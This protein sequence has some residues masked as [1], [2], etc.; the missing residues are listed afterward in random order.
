M[1]HT[2]VLGALVGALLQAAL[3]PGV[4]VFHH[5]PAACLS[6]HSHVLRFELFGW[7]TVLTFFFIMVMYA[8]IFADP[9]HGD[10]GPLAGGLA[11]YAVTST[12]KN[13]Q[14]V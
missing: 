6:P 4:K 2:Q 9:G 5:F 13:Q 8:A 11:V 14:T 1:P 3:V 10:A 7:E 12:G